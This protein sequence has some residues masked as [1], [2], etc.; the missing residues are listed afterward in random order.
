[1]KVHSVTLTTRL[2]VSVACKSVGV[3]GCLQRCVGVKHD[4]VGMCVHLC[5]C[6]FWAETTLF[7]NTS[8]TTYVRLWRTTS[9][10]SMS[11]TENTQLPTHHYDPIHIQYMLLLV[12]LNTWWIFFLYSVDPN[13]LTN[14]NPHT[15]FVWLY[16]HHWTKACRKVKISEDN[17]DML[18]LFQ[19]EFYIRTKTEL[20]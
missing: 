13:A 17:E 4:L 16:F 3:L 7:Q 11:H 12:E 2:T 6:L 8:K 9:C 14:H 19:L 1:M 5:V 20:Q 15:L 10:L 18:K